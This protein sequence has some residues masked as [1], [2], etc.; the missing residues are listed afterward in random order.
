[1]KALPTDV[2]AICGTALVAWGL[3]VLWRHGY[4]WPTVA[5]C[6]ALVLMFLGAMGGS[7]RGQ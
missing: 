2:L 1:M 4:H 6:V 7:V 5:V 3:E